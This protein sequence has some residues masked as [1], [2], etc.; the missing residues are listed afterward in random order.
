MSTIGV[1]QRGLRDLLRLQRR[2]RDRRVV[3]GR[4]TAFRP[5]RSASSSTSTAARPQALVVSKVGVRRRAGLRRRRRRCA[6]SSRPTASPA[7]S[8]ASRSRS[9]ATAMRSSSSRARASS[10][11]ASTGPTIDGPASDHGRSRV[12]IHE[13]QAKALLATYGLPL[14]RGRRDLL[15][16]GGRGG[17]EVAARAGLCGEVA[18]PRRRARQGPVQGARPRRQGRRAASSKSVADVVANAKE[19][20]G[21][22]LVTKQTG[23]A[24]K[25]VNRLYIEAG[26][27]IARELYLLAAGRPRAT[28][29]SPSSSR[30]KAAWTSRPSRTTRPKRSSPSTSIRSTGVTDRRRAEARRRR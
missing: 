25:T 14:R 29:R 24:G 21:K 12:N 11:T 13:H 1:Q 17:G 19:M 23:P 22:T 5:P 10:S 2:R 26:A 9:T 20:L 6:R 4:R 3:R 27:D 30:P 28:A 15:A 7:A 16:G 8:A 18:D